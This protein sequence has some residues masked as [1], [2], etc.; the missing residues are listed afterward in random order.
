MQRNDF[1]RNNA[2][3]EQLKALE[4]S[5]QA[6]PCTELYAPLMHDLF[7][8]HSEDEDLDET[9]YKIEEVVAIAQGLY[10]QKRYAEALSMLTRMVYTISYYFEREEWYSMFDDLNLMDYSPARDQMMELFF[11]MLNDKELP[12]T[13]I[14]PIMRILEA[15]EKEDVLPQYTSWDISPLIK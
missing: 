8:L 10:D 7:S 13:L 15:I 14:E 12:D 6:A 3:I 5:N 11:A 1:L 4:S 9:T 2:L